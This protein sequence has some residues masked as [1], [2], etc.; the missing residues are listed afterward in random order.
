M[1]SKNA[2]DNV[3][4]EDKSKKNGHQRRN[5]RGVNKTRF[6]GEI[7]ELKGHVY[8][9][10]PNKQADQYLVTT[11]HVANYFVTNHKNAGAF[12][13]AILETLTIPVVPP[14]PRPQPATPGGAIDEFDRIDYQA[15]LKERSERVREIEQLNMTLYSVIWSQCSLTMQERVEA[16]NDFEAINRNS[17]GI[18]LLRAIKNV[19]YQQISTAYKID[20]INKAL[21]KLITFQQ[22]EWMSA[23]TYADQFKAKR[24][25]YIQVGGS[26]DASPGSLEF[27]AQE[28]GVDN[29]DDLTAEQRNRARE[30]ELVSLFI[31][32]ADPTRYLSLQRRLQNSYLIGN[33]ENPKTLAMAQTLL[34]E[35]REP[36]NEPSAVKSNDGV[37]FLNNGSGDG[38][39]VDDGDD[40]VTL[41]NNGGQKGKKQRNGKSSYSDAVKGNHGTKQS[42]NKTADDADKDGKES[43]SS[44]QVN[45][46]SSTTTSTVNLNLG[47]STGQLF[48]VSSG[49]IPSTWILLDNQSTVDIFCESSLLDNIHESNH[50]MKVHCNAGELTTNMMGT[51][52]N[53]GTV[54]YSAHGIANIISFANA[55]K[56]GY[57]IR[58][59]NGNNTFIL[60][61]HG[62]DPIMFQ[63][64]PSGLY[65]YDTDATHDSAVT[66]VNTVSENKGKYSH[67]DILRA[68]AARDL[69][70]KIGRPSLQQFLMILDKNQLPNCPVTRRDALM[71]EAIFG[72][73]LGSLKGKTVRR[74]PTPVTVPANDLPADIMAQ[75]QNVTLCGD[76]MFV[77]KIPF[78][79]TISRHIHFSTVE[80]IANKEM[81]TLLTSIK[82]V[83]ALYQQRGFKITE[84]LMDGEFKSLHTDLA[85]LGIQLNTTS[86]DEHVPEIERFIRTLKERTRCIYNTVPFEHMPPRLIIEMVKASCFWLNVFPY[87]HGVSDFLSP[88]QIVTGN[89]IDFNLHCRLAFGTYVQVHEDHD[90]TMAPRT[91]GALALYPTGNQQGGFAFFSLLTGRVIRRNHWTVL[92]MPND[93]IERIRLLAR[94][95]N[96]ARGPLAFYNRF[97]IPIDGVPGHDD[98]ADDDA[99]DDEESYHPP[100]VVHADV[101]GDVDPDDTDD[102]DDGNSNADAAGAPNAY[103]HDDAPDADVEIPGVIAAPPAAEAEAEADPEA[104]PDANPDANP[105]ADPEAE[106]PDVDA[107]FEE[108]PGVDIPGVDAEIAGVDDVGVDDA[109]VP[110][111][112]D[113]GVDDDAI[114]PT[115]AEQMDAEY[116]QRS[117]AYNLRPRQ[118]R[119]YEHLFT[120]Y[121]VQKGLKLFGDAGAAAVSKE[122]QQLHDLGVIKPVAINDLTHDERR[123]ALQYLMFLKQKRC[124]KIKGRGCADGRKQREYLSKEETSSPTV[125][126]E[127]VFLSCVIDADEGRDVA[128]VDVPGAFLH[129]D[130]NDTVHMK[131]N[132]DMAQMLVDIAPDIYGDMISKNKSG[133]PILYV[134]LEKALY[135]TLQAALLFWEKLSALL[136]SWGFVINPYDRCVANKHINGSICTILWHV[137]DLKI[138][139]VDPEVVTEIINQ[140]SDEFGTHAPLSV[141]RGKQH[142]YLGMQLDFSTPSKVRI[143]MT[144]YIDTILEGSPADMKGTSPTPAANHLF[145]VNESCPT[146]LSPAQSEMFH[147]M[148][149]QLLF[150]C[151]RARPD[152]QTAVSFLCTRV[153]RPDTDDYRK[154]ARVIKYLRGTKKLPLTLEASDTKLMSWW[155]DASYGVHHD[156]KS[157]TGGVLTLGKGAVYATST[158]QKLNTKSSTEAEL[159]GVNDV[160]PQVLWTR[161]FLQEQGYGCADAVIY[162]DNKSAILLENNGR[163]SSSKRTRHINIR[164]YFVTDRIKQKEVRVDYCPTEDMIA[165]FFTKPLQGAKF[166]SFRDFILNISPDD[167]IT[168]CN[169]GMLSL[170]PY[171]A[172]GCCLAQSSNH[173]SVLEML[174]NVGHFIS[175]SGKTYGHKMHATSDDQHWHLVTRRQKNTRRQFQSDCADSSIKVEKQQTMKNAAKAHSSVNI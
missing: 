5:H 47:A 60:M 40:G 55:R 76:I 67:R 49:S 50:T 146:Y 115:I 89:T 11:R 139:H 8:D 131:I 156:M 167:E 13:N 138:S 106:N 18:G 136:Q 93:V 24:D 121:T 65:Y 155:V 127:A 38:D 10:V 122:L 153:K 74:A 110:G 71:A 152:I 117:G 172:H 82:A 73:D 85:A 162:Q 107:E 135:G 108:I 133:E 132:G 111:V 9:C 143:S 44:E 43:K 90:N 114:I 157:H 46:Y 81:S 68:E 77:N 96:A 105:E 69:L 94:R 148:V 61:R 126:T 84:L 16:N 147:H 113:V 23:A 59:D 163:A 66:L 54:W 100:A 58:Y 144:D 141:H 79:V 98:D 123:G 101:N 104:D 140:L 2:S 75:Y 159:V 97:G 39:D 14:V 3:K 165:D 22:T 161:Y 175:G 26:D 6:E 125:S 17:D 7:S 25:V 53:Y 150:L 149:A 45:P 28:E 118:R 119:T 86:N 166:T 116:G 160:L 174:D 62:C 87:A 169:V 137:D 92:P 52:R 30:R 36:R 56:N 91:T 158:R 142:D 151:K 4:K 83:T 70:C 34:S 99:D 41:V 129:A 21:I 173:R 15:A 128:I 78:F 20:S 12:R 29:V 1:S 37:A 134:R 88:R 57:D 130:M 32:N 103:F 154:L 120:Q 112:D 168:L 19:A 48:N 170:A 63:Q 145:T 102:D 64:S 95:A 164:Y 171:S 31:M 109:E 80:M 72:P 124:G 35:Y 27:I 42:D 33:N 51:F